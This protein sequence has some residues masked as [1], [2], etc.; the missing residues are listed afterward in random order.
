MRSKFLFLAI[1]LGTIASACSTN[2]KKKDDESE[3][4]NP[5]VY[6]DYRFDH[7]FGRGDR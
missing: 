4:N 6:R 2:P 7:H 5:Q 1:L 3:E